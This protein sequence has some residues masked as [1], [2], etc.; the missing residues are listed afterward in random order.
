MINLE[1]I[2]LRK[3][4]VINLKK[5]LN[6]PDKSQVVLALDFSASMNSLYINGS[7]QE[8][9]ERLLPLGLAFDDNQEV[10]FYLFHHGVI[11]LSETLNLN[12]IDGYIN[13]KVLNKY[14]MGSTN[15]SPVLN[16]ILDD[17][18]ISKTSGGFFGFGGTKQY[19]P[20]KIPVYVIFITDGNNGDKSETISV[21]KE[22]AKAGI[23]IQFVGIGNETFSF[24]Q[25]LDDMND[26]V[27]DNADFFKVNNLSNKTDDELYRLLL[28]EYPSF[29]KQAK[30]QNL[31]S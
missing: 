26:R 19:Q 27:I 29:I 22:L 15:Y 30:Q 11:K 5:E 12:N 14:D 18:A 16:K 7:V 6:L 24:L 10:D 4:K 13:K 17:Y 25:R 3:D 28:N 20:L 2:N 8:L 31:I 9:T 1:K 23:F 21:M